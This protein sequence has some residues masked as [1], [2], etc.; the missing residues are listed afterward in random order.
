[1]LDAIVSRE[2]P[3]IAKAVRWNTPFYGVPG[4]GWFLSF[5]CFTKYLK[6]VFLNGS[7]LQPP[8]P[9]ESKYPAV[10]YW[11]IAEGEDIDEVRLISW[12][13]Q[14]AALPGDRLFSLESE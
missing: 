1:M 11:H 5:H 3:Q 6:V 13:H 4:N 7:E 10:R 2:L 9:I 8:P 14:A 12:I